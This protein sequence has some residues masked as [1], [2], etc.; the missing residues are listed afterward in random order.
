[1]VELVDVGEVGCLKHLLAEAVEFGGV[2]M[3]AT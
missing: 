3:F 2:S 1:V